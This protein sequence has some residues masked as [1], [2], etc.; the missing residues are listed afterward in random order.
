MSSFLSRQ[1]VRRFERGDEWGKK[2]GGGQKKGE[3]VL[4][5]ANRTQAVVSLTVYDVLYIYMYMHSAMWPVDSSSSSSSLFFSFPLLYRLFHKNQPSASSSWPSC[6][7]VAMTFPFTYVPP[8]RLNLASLPTNR[9]SRVFFF[10]LPCFFSATIH[11][12]TVLPLTILFFLFFFFLGMT[13]IH[14]FFFY[15]FR[16]KKKF[17]GSYKL[18]YLYLLKYK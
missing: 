13:K 9:S 1:R 5:I 8:P 16:G 18:Y 2:L 11:T 10:T 17:I 4:L 7:S 15:F 12:Q 3:K 6:R 14:I